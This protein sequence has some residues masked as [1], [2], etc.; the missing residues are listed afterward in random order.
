[1]SL[2]EKK[3]PWIA[4]E[5]SLEEQKREL[6]VEPLEAEVLN[7]LLRWTWLHKGQLEPLNLSLSYRDRNH[8]RY[9]DM[10]FSL[11]ILM[12][13]VSRSSFCFWKNYNIWI[14]SGRSKWGNAIK[15]LQN[16]ISGK[17]QFKGF[18]FMNLRKMPQINLIDAKSAKLV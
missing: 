12:R 11:L 14:T 1:M 13:N 7:G 2:L 16:L 15:L 3:S 4:K 10:N 18:I 17:V 5:W 9:S 6:H 8:G